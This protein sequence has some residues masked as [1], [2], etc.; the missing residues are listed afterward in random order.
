MRK[1]E[2]ELTNAIRSKA[3]HWA[4]G[5]TMI[6]YNEDTD[7]YEV[8]LH[9]YNIASIDRTIKRVKISS[10]GYQTNVTKSRLNTILNALYINKTI[11]QK[12]GCWVIDNRPFC[13]G[14]YV[15]FYYN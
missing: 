11:A 9:G 5:N 15:P 7:T 13:D 1:I 8:Y 10:C 14:V 3:K 6:C 12:N 2:N 4:N